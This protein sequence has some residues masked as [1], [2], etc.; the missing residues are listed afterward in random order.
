LLND[1]GLRE[2]SAA[3]WSSGARGFAGFSLPAYSAGGQAV[4]YAF[5]LCGNVCGYG[6][7]VLLRHGAAGW[8]IQA[9]DMLW[10]S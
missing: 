2:Q 6:W 8:E 9:A 4:V 10:V 3:L 1:L 7:F 5:Y